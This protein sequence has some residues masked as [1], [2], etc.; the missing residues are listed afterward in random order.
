[1]PTTRRSFLTAAALAASAGCRTNRLPRSLVPAAPKDH[2]AN[3][4]STWGV[5]SR[6]GGAAAP[7]PAAA[8]AQVAPADS[9][10]EEKLFSP[11]GW[12]SAFPKV[13]GEMFL[14]V[15]LGWDVPVG[16]RFDQERWRL[17]SQELDPTKFPSCQGDPEERL[18]RLAGLAK[19]AGWSGAGLWVAAQAYGEGRNESR[20][21]ERDLIRY[22]RERLQWSE[23]AGIRYW[24][25]DSGVRSSE[26]EFRGRISSIAEGEAPNLVVEHSR[27]GGPLNDEPCPWDLS[28]AS[29]TG[30]FR[31]WGHG[32][33]LRESSRI[34]YLSRVF[35]TSGVTARLSIPT[36]IDRVAELLRDTA[37]NRDVDCI[38]NCED[39]PYIAAVL[40]CTMG[41][42][43]HPAWRSNES[44]GADPRRTRLRIAEVTRAVRWHRIAPPWP[45]GDSPVQLDTRRL[46]DAW[47]FGPGETW[48]SWESGHTVRQSAPARVTRNMPLERLKTPTLEPPFLVASLHPNGATA[49]A[50]LS[51]IAPLGGFLYPLVDVELEVEEPLEPI[52]VFGSYRSLTLVCDGPPSKFRLLAQDLAG[53]T[54]IDIT[55]D[56]RVEGTRVTLPG[57]LLQRVGTS[58]QPAGDVSDPGLV[59]RLSPA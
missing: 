54:P 27:D 6:A 19:N 20:L 30:R 35:R 25:V 45:A 9:L 10:R 17:G 3:Y 59:L 1:V 55:S 56:V 49:V 50:T 15:D 24:K 46:E 44:A 36:T 5:Q 14:L 26:P 23:R 38:L 58:A 33:A 43:R 39:E 4:W 11:G 51:R 42:L 13:R 37:G 7:L 16:T 40:G 22:F 21:P 29:R 53:D 31:F 18:R 41:I 34:A 32:E 8:A 57:P 47:T 2:A 48:V 28:P 12:A 52:G